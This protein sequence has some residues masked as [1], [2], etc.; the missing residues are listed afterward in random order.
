VLAGGQLELVA[1]GASWPVLKGG[2]L[3]ECSCLGSERKGVS[4]A[5]CANREAKAPSDTH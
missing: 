4:R 3:K 5:G 1:G 2:V